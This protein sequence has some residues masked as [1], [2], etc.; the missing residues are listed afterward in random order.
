MSI[1]EEHDFVFTEEDLDLIFCDDRHRMIPKVVLTPDEALLDPIPFPLDS[2][3]DL[4][5]LSH[6]VKEGRVLKDC[7]RLP[8]LYDVIEELHQLIGMTSIK[9]GLCNMMLFELQNLPCHFRHMVLTGKPGAGKTKIATVI[10]KLLKC[11]GILPSDEIV[12]TTPKFLI[13]DS[14]CKTKSRVYKIVQEAL[15]KSG[16]LL[17]DEAHTFGPA[18]SNGRFCLDVL[19][20]LMDRYPNSL[21]VIF[22][23]LPDVT[24]RTILQAND[25]VRSRLQWFF[26][27]DD[28][29]SDELHAI[30]CQKL[31]ELKYCLTENS[32]FDAS[33]FAAHISHFPAMGRSIDHWIHKLR[34]IHCRKTFG[35]ID[36]TT[37][38]DQTIQEAF[39]FYVNEQR[40]TSTAPQLPAHA[41][42]FF[43]PLYRHK[44]I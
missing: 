37:V 36:Q 33:W 5:R 2:F 1:E 44:F 27:L 15:A 11:L 8:M 34:H 16:V 17:I 4:R 26:H 10:T 42:S 25:S 9:D 32:T 29:T 6:L 21:L 18:T 43:S 39:E 23:G 3:D 22:S 19:I 38:K 7:Q 35:Q 40:N 20:N 24:E 30:F 12:L 31:S 14:E 41:M 28:Y 13:A